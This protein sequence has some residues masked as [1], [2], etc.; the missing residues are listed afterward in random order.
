MTGILP[1]D[2]SIIEKEREMKL[3]LKKMSGFIAIACALLLATVVGFSQQGRPPG[4]PP[5][6]GFHGGP[7]PRDGLGPLARDLNLSDDQKTQIKKITD[8]F[9]EST[10]ALRD[11]LRTLHESEPDPLSGGAFDE[12][13]VRAAAQARANVQVELEVA[14]ARLMS[15]VFAILT[16]EQKAQLA[17]KRQE[18]EQRR[19]EGPPRG[20]APNN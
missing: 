3:K 5:G 18:F 12:A 19:G 17:A 10:K 13:A 2:N 7:G 14:H 8:S 9:E 20:D 15:Q 16:T 11:Q 1:T 6:G 4:P